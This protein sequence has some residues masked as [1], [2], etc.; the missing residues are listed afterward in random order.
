MGLSISGVQF[1]LNSFVDVNS[2]VKI[3]VIR[4]SGMTGLPSQEKTAASVRE[5]LPLSLCYKL[6][7]FRLFC[8]RRIRSAKLP[9]CLLEIADLF[10][11]IG[12]LAIFTTAFFG[13]SS[14][15]PSSSSPIHCGDNFLPPCNCSLIL[16]RVSGDTLSPISASSFNTRSTF[17]SLIFGSRLAS[18][19]RS[20]KPHSRPVFSFNFANTLVSTPGFTGDSPPL[21]HK[22]ACLCFSLA[23]YEEESKSVRRTPTSNFRS[24]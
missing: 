11:G 12:G 18:R 13:G 4:R 6:L 3:N 21:S 2:I 10:L 5:Q 22:G 1:R 7:L 23:G 8:M 20:F 19:M 24:V 17:L 15:L 16:F 9:P 14:F